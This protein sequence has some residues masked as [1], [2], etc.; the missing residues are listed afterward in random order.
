[1]GI[2]NRLEPCPSIFFAFFSD[3]CPVAAISCQIR[4]DVAPAKAVCGCAAGSGLGDT[5]AKVLSLRSPD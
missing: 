1:M 2:V 3:F 4:V 5:A